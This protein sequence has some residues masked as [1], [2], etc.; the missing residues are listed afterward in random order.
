[1]GISVAGGLGPRQWARL[2]A[3]AGREVPGEAGRGGL[4]GPFPQS[5]ERSRSLRPSAESAEAMAALSVL[6]PRGRNT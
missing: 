4:P 5:P 6:L 2:S 1:M 3:P